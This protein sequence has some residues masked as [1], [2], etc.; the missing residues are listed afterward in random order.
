MY[1][2]RKSICVWPSRKHFLVISVSSNLSFVGNQLRLKVLK[3]SAEK[4]STYKCLDIIKSARIMIHELDHRFN[5]PYKVDH[6]C[7][8]SNMYKHYKLYKLYKHKGI[9]SMF[10]MSP[11]S[12]HPC[13]RIRVM[14]DL[15]NT[16]L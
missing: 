16:D 6:V 14:A 13:I 5:T 15:I 2:Q 9:F 8:A 7:N 12:S 1:Q 11:C 4:A 10:I 3:G